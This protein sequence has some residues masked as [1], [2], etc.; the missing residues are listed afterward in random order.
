MPTDLRTLA[1]SALEDLADQART[2]Y[3]SQR[4]SA[5]QIEHAVREMLL[6]SD[7]RF[8]P[9]VGVR[10]SGDILFRDDVLCHINIKTTDISK[11]F[12]M[13]NLISAAN[14]KKILDRGERFYLL[15]VLH[16]SG[17]IR[18]KEFWDIREIDWKH[19]QLGA[20]GTGQIQ[21]RN[22][23]NPLT[24]HEHTLEDWVKEWRQQMQRFYRK[25]IDKANRR[26][27]EWQNH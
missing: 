18:S 6:S 12:H 8:A 4:T 17:E 21:I 10:A 16:E 3:G 24:A 7:R 27:M 2:D 14:L 9:P 23:L 26:L 5:D 11:D 1:L 13:P 22:G 25:E 20:L 19:L 15:R